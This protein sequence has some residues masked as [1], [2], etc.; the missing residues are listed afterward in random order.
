MYLMIRKTKPGKSQRKIW[1]NEVWTRRQA[2]LYS[3]SI[4]YTGESRFTKSATS[5]GAKKDREKSWRARQG[6]KAIWELGCSRAGCGTYQS[7]RRLRYSFYAW[8][9]PDGFKQTIGPEAENLRAF[10]EGY[11]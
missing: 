6:A 7:S 10:F 5:S 9:N 1:R 11:L 3:W 8:N 4:E 2:S